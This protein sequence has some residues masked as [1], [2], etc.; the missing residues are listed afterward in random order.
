MTRP[1]LSIAVVWLVAVACGSGSDPPHADSHEL[2]PQKDERPGASSE[3]VPLTA[4]LETAVDQ[5][6]AGTDEAPYF[7]GGDVEPPERLEG[8]ML[9]SS[10]VDMM[11][12]GHYAWGACI[13]TVTI[14]ETGEV[15]GFQFLK[16]TDLA[17]EVE[18]AIID[19]V[20]EWRFSPATR[21]GQPVA[22]YYSLVI[23][24]CPYRR[25][26]SQSPLLEE[27]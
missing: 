13:F 23:H 16:P 24:H 26:E 5:T 9:D 3:P 19:T 21:A 25:L 2:Q 10:L 17:P 27:G 20:E 12:S 15:S 7:V 22:V 18:Q 6:E 14:S 11:R 1:I 8:S 4:D